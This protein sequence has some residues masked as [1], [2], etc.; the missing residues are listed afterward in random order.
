VA[1]GAQILAQQEAQPDPVPDSSSDQVDTK[2]PSSKEELFG[3]SE[4]D[5]PAKQ[6]RKI[7][8]GGFL[9]EKVARS[10]DDPSHWSRILSRARVSAKQDLG[11]GLSWKATGRLDYDAAYDALDFYP[12]AV[13]QDQRLNFFVEDTYLD[14]SAGNWDLRLGRQ[15]IVWGEVVG[16]F[17]ADVVSAKD[18][19]EFILPDFDVVRIPQWAARAEYFKG[20]Y[21]AELIWIPVP[22]YDRIGYPGA[23]YY[24]FPPVPPGV[25]SIIAGEQKPSWTL[26]NTN[27][28]ARGSMLKGG[29]DISALYYHSLDAQ[30]AFERTAIIPGPTPTY[31]LQPTHFKIWQAGG[32]VSKDL[33]FVAVKG[34]AIY[35]KD[36]MFSSLDPA[37]PTGLVAQNTLDSALGIDIPLPKDS[38]VN[39]QWLQRSFTNHASFT[40]FDRVENAV[41]ALITFPKISKVQPEMLLIQSTNRNDRLLSLKLRWSVV[42]NLKVIAGADIFHGPPLGLFGQFD[43]KDRV[44]IDAVYSF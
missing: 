41:S 39:L 44:Y 42:P 9:E 21:H 10:Y 15:N 7:T 36:R 31:V 28:G 16:A 5:K 22:T 8:W 26:G 27:I 37:N 34:E 25:N 11:N 43:N 35:T 14:V 38:R 3:V 33:G 18:F 6:Q 19:R 13:R 32:T 12:P 24:A 2:E 40:I 29:W 17:V 1:G 4:G 30:Q 20:D 23:E